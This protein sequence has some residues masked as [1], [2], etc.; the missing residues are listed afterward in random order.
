MTQATQPIDEAPPE[1]PL[2][3]RGRE[4]AGRTFYRLRAQPLVVG[5]IGFVVVLF[6]AVA[7]GPVLLPQ[8]AQ[9][10]NLSDAFMSPSLAHPLG[11]DELG[12]DLMSRVL[13][14]GRSSILAAGEAVGI[15]IVLGVP[16][17]ILAGYFRGVID[18]VV[19]RATDAA[20]SFPPLLLAITVVA[21]LGPGLVNAMAAV[22][23]VMAPRFVRLARGTAMGVREETYVEASLSIGT[24]PLRIIRRHVVPNV[25]SP[26]IVQVSLTIGYAMLA[27]SSLSFLGLGIQP[28]GVSWGSMLD[29]AAD[30]M[31]RSSMLIIV[32]GVAI[33]LTVLAFNVI[34]DGLND[35]IGRE[36]RT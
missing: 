21:I 36:R 23:I 1:N 24:H 15:S 7:L 26:L 34:G 13:L 28:P 31:G 14:A 4:K 16:I 2:Q 12:R 22:G 27:E 19:M 33:A 18:S 5:A 20:M 8:D 32:P 30:H 11:T 35:S 10:Q 29:R 3:S 9:Q 6:F 17:G 25:L